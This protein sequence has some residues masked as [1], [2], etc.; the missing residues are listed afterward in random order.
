MTIGFLHIQKTAGTSFVKHVEDV[1]GDRVHHYCNYNTLYGLQDQEHRSDVDFFFGHLTFQ[2][3]FI[4]H[5]SP[6]IIT[7]LRDPV[8]RLFSQYHH[9]RAYFNPANPHMALATRDEKIIADE[10]F[11]QTSS[12]AEFCGNPKS[13]FTP[14][15]DYDNAL[16]RAISGVGRKAR[17][18]TV[19]DYILSIA[20]RNLDKM[21]FVGFFETFDE[22]VAKFF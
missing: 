7:F 21:W 15:Q 14:F 22:S 6:K 1:F 2:E 12:F 11:V 10:L 19:D 18:G 13:K 4:F 3:M 16:V 9:H 20:K 17:H 5:E 8:D